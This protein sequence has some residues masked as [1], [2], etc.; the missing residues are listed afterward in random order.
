M[1]ENQEPRFKN[2]ELRLLRTVLFLGLI[3]AFFGC[4]TTKTITKSGIN[5]ISTV[6][7]MIEKIQKV[8]PHFTSANISKMSLALELGERKINSSASCKI[9]KDSAIF[10]SIQP[11]MGIELFKVEMTLDSIR[12][13]DKMNNR[14]YE[15]DYGFF[16]K[17]FGVDVDF[18]CLQALLFGQFFC[19]GQKEIQVDSCR[20]NGSNK[21]EYQNKDMLQSTE[22]NADN[23]LK[24]VLLKAHKGSYQLQTDYEDYTKQD[25]VNFPQKIIFKASDQ[26]TKGSSDFSILRVVF[27]TELSFKSTNPAKFSKGNIEQLLNK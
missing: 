7:K 1:I 2:Q 23:S 10:V 16:S 6:A 11:F 26:K 3:V 8:E 20:I 24:Q 25:S 14:F 21:I 19:I 4:K 15:V 18:Y 17:R 5:E 9:R 12:V 27:N 13:F 22:I